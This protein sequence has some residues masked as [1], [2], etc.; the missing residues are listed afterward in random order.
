[1]TETPLEITCADVKAR[2]DAGDDLLLVDC[3]EQNEYDLVC[4][5][6]ATLLPMNELQDRVGELQEHKGRS[7]VVHCHHGGRSLRVVNWLR[8]QGFDQAQS[9]AGGIDVWAQEVEPGMVRY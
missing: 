9:M 7:I 5:A 3:R 2:Q 6:G 4:I 8:T 1:M